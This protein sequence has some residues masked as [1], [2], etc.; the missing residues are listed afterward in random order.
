MKSA[1][2]A[3]LKSCFLAILPALIVGCA[4]TAAEVTRS[5][6]HVQM[7]HYSFVLPLLKSYLPDFKSTLQTLTMR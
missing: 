3:G 4:S 1:S 5:N 6:S 2:G 7:P